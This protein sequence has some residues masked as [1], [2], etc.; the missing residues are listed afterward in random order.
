MKTSSAKITDRKDL[1]F[2]IS[3]LFIAGA[4]YSI[5]SVIVHNHFQTFGWDLGFFDQIIWKV[6]RGDFRAYS[7]LA[8]ENLLADH[9]QPVLYLLAPFIRVVSDVRVL[10]IAQAFLVVMAAYPLYL[11]SRSLTGNIIFSLGAVFSYLLFLG[12]QWTILNEFHQTAFLPLFISL[13]FYS[14]M[15]RNNILYW[16]SIAGI[17]AT[18]EEYA[19][20]VSSL[21][22]I[23]WWVYRKRLSGIMTCIFGIIFF[24]FLINFLMPKLSVGGVYF[25]ND[26]GR[27]GYTS[28]QVI[29]NSIKNPKFFFESMVFPI[30]K[31]KTVFNSFLAFGFLPVLSPLFLIPVVENFS[32]RFI[33]AGPQFTQWVNVNQ[34]AAPLGIL[35]SVGSIYSSLV[36]AKIINRKTKIKT[37]RILTVLGFYLIFAGIIQNILL[38]GPV[39]SLFKRQF[40]ETLDWMN[41]NNMVIAKVPRDVSLATQNSM[42]PHVSQRKDI[43]LLPELGNAQY[44]LLDL[45]DGPNK[46]SPLKYDDMQIFAQKLLDGGKYSVVYKRGKAVLLKRND[47]SLK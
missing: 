37:D 18:K 7:S 10:L 23:C 29:L 9:F 11:L 3:I 34:H 26:F 47:T 46:F 43:Y 31:V 4:I 30:I 15:K 22:I 5:I 27:A 17:L 33:Y 21:G 16:V 44:V 36:L 19:L 8:H 6:S 12:T 42:L 39:N 45:S 24:F 32:T 28:E 25:H 2:L 38:H 20:L 13:V 1:I 41:D 40:Y 35:L 14:L